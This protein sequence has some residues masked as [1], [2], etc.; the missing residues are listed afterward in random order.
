MDL[1]TFLAA[2]GAEREVRSLSCDQTHPVRVIYGEVVIG[3]ADCD[4]TVFG[5]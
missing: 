3:Q 5:W 4:V 1:A 2:R